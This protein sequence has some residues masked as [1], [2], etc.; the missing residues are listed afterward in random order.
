[1]RIAIEGVFPEAEASRQKTRTAPEEP[2]GTRALP[3]AVA[4]PRVEVTRI[5]EAGVFRDGCTRRA[6]RSCET[7]M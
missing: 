5:P 1:M 3:A 6:N 7:R 4:C 2:E